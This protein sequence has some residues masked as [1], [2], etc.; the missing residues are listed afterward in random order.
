MKKIIIGLISILVLANC[1]EP[2]QHNY[3]IKAYNGGLYINGTFQSG[4]TALKTVKEG[5][6]INVVVDNSSWN[7]R[8]MI[9]REGLTILDKSTY[10]FGKI[11]ITFSYENQ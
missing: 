1:K 11:D 6:P 10:N 5:E 8:L 2:R 3:L 9:S 4:N 7:P